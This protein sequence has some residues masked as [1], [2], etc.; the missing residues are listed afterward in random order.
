LPDPQIHAAGWQVIA[1]N[2]LAPVIVDL[3]DRGMADLLAV[4][5]RLVLGGII[6]AQAEEVLA[7]LERQGLRVL[8]RDQEGDWVCLVAGP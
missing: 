8:E 3:L 2:I 1:A 6:E 4:D 5:G 7:A